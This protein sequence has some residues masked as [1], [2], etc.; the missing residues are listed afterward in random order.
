MC[1]VILCKGKLIVTIAQ[2]ASHLPPGMKRVGYDTDTERYTF[3]QGD[4]LWLGE[5]GSFYGGELK[6]AGRASD[7]DSEDND[8]EEYTESSGS[9]SVGDCSE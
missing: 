1:L 3:R 2:D 5:P 7:A 4:D 8:D 9:E 6:W